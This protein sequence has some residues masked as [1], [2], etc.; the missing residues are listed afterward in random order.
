MDAASDVAALLAA[1]PQLTVLATSRIALR[2]RG[3]HEFAVPPLALP[4]PK[5]LPPLERLS[6]YEA[7]RLFI[8]RA[9]AVK[10]DFA[11]T[12]ATAPAVAEICVRLDGLPLAIELAAARIRLLSPEA[13]LAR[14]D[15]RL[16]LLTG[17][18]RDLPA[19]QRTLRAAIDWSY[20]LLDPAAHSSSAAW[21]SSRVAAPWGRSEVCNFDGQLQGD[22]LDGVE[23]LLSSSLLQQRSGA[24]GEAHFGMLE[25]IHEFAR[26]RLQETAEVQRAPACARALLRPPGGGGGTAP[27]QPRT[28]RLARPIGRG[29][30]QRPRGARVGGGPRHA[31]HP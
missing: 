7:V 31:A 9:V 17:G 2:L 30:G 12:N 26:E 18:P 27:D 10:A 21:P 15:Q 29:A 1:C 14:L 23:T 6:Q 22:V 19:R 5:Q 25:T 13:L 20:D 16:K 28:A 11:V 3:E 8:D 4:D 24:D